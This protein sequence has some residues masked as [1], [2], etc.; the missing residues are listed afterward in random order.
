MPLINSI[1]T[2]LNTKRLSQIDFFKDH[3]IE[4]QKEVLSQ[5]LNRA[6]N[7]EWGIKYDFK[8]I[9]NLNT[10]KNRIPIT[11]YNTISDEIGRLR[12]GEHNIFWPTEVK[13]FAKSS[14]TTN[15]KSKFI[16]VTSDAL[17]D[18]HFRGGKDILAMY[19]A[20]Y[21]ETKILT[22]KGL[23]LGGSHQINNMSNES[24]YGDLSAIL[25][26]N[27]PFWADFIRTPSS[28]IA[29]IEKWEEKLEKMLEV[30]L[31]ENVTSLS[32]VPS[33]YLVLLKHILEHTGCNNIHEIW[34]NLEVFVHGGV[35]FSPYRKQFEKILPSPDMHYMETYNASEGFFGIQDSPD[36]QAMLLM[37]DY[38]IYYEFIPLENIND[39]NPIVLSL[40]DVELYKNYAMLITTNGGLWRYNIGDTLNFTSLYPFKFKISGRT[41][42]FINAFGEELIIENAENALQTACAKTNAIIKEYSAAPVYMDTKTKGGH[43]WLIEFEKKPNNLDKFKYLLDNALMALNSDYEAKRYKNITLAPPTII[44]AKKDLFYRWLK[45]EGKLGGQNKVPRLSNNRD[46]MDKLLALNN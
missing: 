32:G 35:N 12:R 23:T 2:W 9:D 37:L 16:P 4:I 1:V 39:E 18:C 28:S 5:L 26:Q 45:N 25:I 3:P 22:G 46:L 21:P 38:G 27:L 11:E 31:D 15:S 29:L 10:F 43:Q 41:K 33:W 13:W 34:P 14:G 20:Q 40:E 24:Y 44:I 42:L 7:T 6:Q 8:S 19:T 30:T 36:D 17:E